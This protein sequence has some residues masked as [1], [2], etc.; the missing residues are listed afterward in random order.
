[1][2]AGNFRSHE[3]AARPLGVEI[4]AAER[5]LDEGFASG[6]IGPDMLRGETAAIAELQGKG[7]SS[8]AS[9]ATVVRRFFAVCACRRFQPFGGS[10]GNRWVRP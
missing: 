5:R 4:L 1:M 10:Q 7:A 6:L 3:C 9:R 8:S 2:S